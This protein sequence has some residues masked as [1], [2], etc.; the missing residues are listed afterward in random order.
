MFDSY[1]LYSCMVVERP[2]SLSLSLSLSAPR[3]E[4][5]FLAFGE[6]DVE[7]VYLLA[8]TVCV[9]HAIIA[10]AAITGKALLN[11]TARQLKR[12]ANNVHNN[13]KQTVGVG[14]GFLL[15]ESGISE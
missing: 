6:C 13:A 14:V 9:L 15:L 7:S 4:V 11:C 2:L 3:S 12:G 10:H 1:S 8:Y 5:I